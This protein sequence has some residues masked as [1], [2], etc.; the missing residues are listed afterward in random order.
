RGE[1]AALP[2]D[3]V[4]GRVAGRARSSGRT[5]A[6]CARIVVL[7]Y[8][9]VVGVRDINVARA[10]HSH[11]RWEAQGVCAHG[12]CAPIAVGRGEVAALAEDQVGGCIAGRAWSARRASARRARIVVLENT[13][14]SGVG[15]VEVAGCIRRDRA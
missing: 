11:A 6:R 1:V 9:A 5:S 14:I 10:I 4:G 12:A 15:Y 3:Q 13:A 2:E 8:A 7:E